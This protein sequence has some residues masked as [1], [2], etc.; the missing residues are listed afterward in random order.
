MSCTGCNDGCNDCKGSCERVVIDKRGLT[1]PQGPPGPQGERGFPGTN[2]TNGQ[3]GASYVNKVNSY[4]EFIGD[5]DVKDSL[6]NPAVYHFPPGYEVLTYTNNTGETKPFIVHGSWDTLLTDPNSF[7][8]EN[9][10]DGAIVKTVAAVDSVEYE[11]LSLIDVSVSL[12]DGAGVGDTINI[13]S[14]PDTVD[15]APGGNPTE[16]RFASASI[17]KNSSIFKKV[18]LNDG[19]SISLKFKTKD[20]SSNSRLRKAQLFVN[21]LDQ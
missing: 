9:W 5:V 18:F 20:A 16:V 3:D 15:T 7:D 17:P 1:G 10:V 6:P 2:G 19:E 12:F 4:N 11:S 8:I 21:E 14:A 13:A